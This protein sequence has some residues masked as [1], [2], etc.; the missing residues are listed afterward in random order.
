MLINEIDKSNLNSIEKSLKLLCVIRRAERYTAVHG[1]VELFPCV[2]N[3]LDKILEWK[4]S[5]A[6]ELPFLKSFWI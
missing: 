6:T 3:A 4:D 2:I 5:A 1:F